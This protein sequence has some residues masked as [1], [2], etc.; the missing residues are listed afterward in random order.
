MSPAR[1]HSWI[2]AAGGRRFLL[3]LGCGAVNSVLLVAGYL[4]ENGYVQLILGTVAAFIAGAT[5]RRDR[6]PTK[7]EDR[8]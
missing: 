7:G 2:E 8:E 3:A 1:L 4:S 5:L 6:H